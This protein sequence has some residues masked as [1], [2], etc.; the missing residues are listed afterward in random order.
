MFEIRLPLLKR[1]QSIAGIAGGI[2]FALGTAIPGIGMLAYSWTCPFGDDVFQVVGFLAITGLVG[3]I[4]FGNLV[5][6]T[7]I[8]IAKLKQDS[9][10]TSQRE[11]DPDGN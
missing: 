2:G 3:A 8:G 6:F 7:L 9:R 4:V 1:Y 5:A 11:G 10:K